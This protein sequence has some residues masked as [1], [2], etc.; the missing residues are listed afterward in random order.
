[1][2]VNEEAPCYMAGGYFRSS[3]FPKY[4]GEREGLA[5]R[6]VTCQPPVWLMWRETRPSTVWRE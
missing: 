2:T 5:P 4:P 6:C 3:L 1:M